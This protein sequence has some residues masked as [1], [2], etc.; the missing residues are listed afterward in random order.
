[1]NFTTAAK[2]QEMR[3]AGGCQQRQQQAKKF[4]AELEDMLLAGEYQELSTAWHHYRSGEGS[5]ELYAV[6]NRLINKYRQGPPAR[7]SIICL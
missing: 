4:M 5:V 6:C 3:N 7:T 2:L 1:M